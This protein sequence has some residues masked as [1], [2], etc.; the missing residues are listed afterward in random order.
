VVGG[1]VIW[2]LPPPDQPQVKF[3]ALFLDE[4]GQ[5]RI[6]A[7][8]LL[9]GRAPQLAPSIPRGPRTGVRWPMRL[10]VLDHQGLSIEITTTT[11]PGLHAPAGLDLG[12][13]QRLAADVEEALAS[14]RPEGVPTHW[15]PMHGDMASWNLRHYP[16]GE[17]F[18]L[19]W[20]ES[21]WAPPH[22]DL[23][24]FLMTAPHGE[25][26]AQQLAAGVASEMD[27]AVEFWR[28]RL[29]ASAS[30]TSP[31]W[32]SRKCMAQ[33]TNLDAISRPALT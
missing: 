24:R 14:T 23:V 4:R 16:N 8:V 1:Q 21:D 30:D 18:L 9:E 19:D 6:F 2:H 15:Q 28:Q 33:A 29:T 25:A 12:C 31:D 26:L 13:A 3:G 27:E 17:T 20:E 22:A 11:P 32:V 7:R 10:A 5:S